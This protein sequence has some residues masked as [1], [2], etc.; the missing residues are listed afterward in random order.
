M[1]DN[2]SFSLC[3]LV[4]NED[5]GKF[6]DMAGSIVFDNSLAATVTVLTVR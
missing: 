4:P 1:N 3:S 5:T 6:K 2:K